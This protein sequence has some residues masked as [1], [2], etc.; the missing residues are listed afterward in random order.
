MHPCFFNDHLGCFPCSTLQNRKEQFCMV[1]LDAGL[2]MSLGLKDIPRNTIQCCAPLQ[3]AA[4]PL[5]IP[6]GYHV[7][8]ML[9]TE[10]DS[11]LLC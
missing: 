11:R 9:R 2:R 6:E 3:W 7:P 1:L 5:K 10:Q 4:R 8:L